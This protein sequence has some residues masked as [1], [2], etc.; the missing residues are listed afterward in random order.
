ME[1]HNVYGF[2]LGHGTYICNDTTDYTVAIDYTEAID[3]TV[4]ID[5]M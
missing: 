2:S 1:H 3:Y 5:N 4:A